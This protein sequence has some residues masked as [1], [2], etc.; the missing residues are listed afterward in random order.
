MCFLTNISE[1]PRY[2]DRFCFLQ[3]CRYLNEFAAIKNTNMQ[4][5]ER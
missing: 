4:Q 1:N 3:V 2:N 5:Y